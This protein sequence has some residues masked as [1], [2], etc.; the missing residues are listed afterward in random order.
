[1]RVNGNKQQ[2]EDVLRYLQYFFCSYAVLEYYNPHFILINVNPHYSIV[3]KRIN[4]H[5]YCKIY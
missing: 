4:L 3:Y 5:L 1:M 2:I